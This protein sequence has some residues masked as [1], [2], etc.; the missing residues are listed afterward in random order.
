MKCKNINFP[1]LEFTA[2]G[3]YTYVM[4]ELSPPDEYWV[5]DERV[6]RV[7]VTVVEKSDGTLEASVE[8]IDGFP[9]FVNYYCPVPPPPPCDV[10][11]HFDCLPFPMFWF[12]PPQKPEFKALMESSPNA[13]EI[14][15]SAMEYVKNYCD[16]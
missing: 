3:R 7:V 15:D 9:E 16:K 10:C 6:Y 2:P 11:K 5:T 8:Y 4:K 12:A 1:A 13:F 14:W